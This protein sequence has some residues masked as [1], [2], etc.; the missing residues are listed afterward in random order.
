[1]D[2]SKSKL[3]ALLA[4]AAL[5]AMAGCSSKGPPRAPAF[6]PQFA[7]TLNETATQAAV[8]KPGAKVCR[9]IQ[10]GIAERDWIR[11]VVSAISDRKVT[12]TIEN[13]GRFPHEL[14][15]AA[16]VRGATVRDDPSAWIPCL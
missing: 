1:M 12:V 10:V 3:C 5:V 8:A 2:T 4:G 11:G 7:H 16:V 14:N 6:D 9:T 15:G 13:A